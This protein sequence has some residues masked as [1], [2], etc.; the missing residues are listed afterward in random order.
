MI[1]ICGCN[2]LAS[3]VLAYQR[4][5]LRETPIACVKRLLGSWS[6]HS[7]IEVLACQYLAQNALVGVDYEPI[8]TLNRISSKT[9]KEGTLP[10]ASER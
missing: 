10:S 4:T 1:S 6:I 9:V 5:V 8:A 2:V 7:V 3:G